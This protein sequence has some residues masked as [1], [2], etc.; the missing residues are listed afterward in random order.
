MIV[1][2][3]KGEFNYSYPINVFISLLN[4]SEF[5]LKKNNC[6]Q[7]SASVNG[8]RL[9]H[10]TLL[11]SGRGELKVRGGVSEGAPKWVQEFRSS[12]TAYSTFNTQ[13]SDRTV[14]A[15]FMQVNNHMYTNT[16]ICIQLH[17]LMHLLHVPFPPHCNSL[18]IT[19]LINHTIR[20]CH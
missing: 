8:L 7:S 3:L 1:E 19:L 16:L 12:S 2:S 18:H 11:Q 9:M 17:T 10:T 13:P 4:S 14:V 5:S 6:V 20:L 15:C